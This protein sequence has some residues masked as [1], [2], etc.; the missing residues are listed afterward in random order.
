MSQGDKGETAYERYASDINRLFS[1]K[2]KYLRSQNSLL[3]TL[4]GRGQN[5][6]KV[7]Y[8]EGEIVFLNGSTPVATG[9]FEII[10]SYASDSKNWIWY[11]TIP[12]KQEKLSNISKSI[13]K[14]GEDENLSV[15]RHGMIRG[16]DENLI[17]YLCYP[18]FEFGGSG[19]YKIRYQDQSDIYLYIC[20]TSID[21][22]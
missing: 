9:K 22:F 2:Q 3:T 1:Y 17:W 14:L 20:L 15:L 12:T 8:D 11:H 7:N 5:Q 4:K 21:F 19:F 6:V 18:S 10:G 16:V 13:A